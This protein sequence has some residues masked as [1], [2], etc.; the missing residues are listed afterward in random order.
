MFKEAIMM[1]KNRAEQYKKTQI[2]TSSP[3]KLLL[4]L[5]QGAIKFSKLA[6]QN[7][8]ADQIED[9]HKNII[10]VQNI[11]LELKSTLDKEKGG[12]LA[13]QLEKLYDF[14]YQELLQANLKKDVK[15]LNNI[16]PL[17]EELYTAY[18]EI[19]LNQKSPEFKKVNLG[20]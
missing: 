5:Y 17:L 4:M 10:K 15:H 16:I 11:V 6:I 7:I 12:Q 3:G 20:G 9:S 14:I 19:V 1:N 13:D 2:N 8:E 18:K